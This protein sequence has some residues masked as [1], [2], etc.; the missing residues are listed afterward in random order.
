MAIVLTDSRGVE[1]TLPQTAKIEGF[2]F[3]TRIPAN[4]VPGRP[5]AIVSTSWVAK[6]SIKGTLRVLYPGDTNIAAETWRRVLAAIFAYP[7]I[8]LVRDTSIDDY[9]NVWC[10]NI[11]A[12]YI[13]RTNMSYIELTCSLVAH[14]P[15]FNATELTEVDGEITAV[16]GNIS[17]TNS[18]TGLVRPTITIV[19]SGTVGGADQ[20]TDITIVN[21]TTNQTI[22]YTGNLEATDT[23]VLDCENYTAKINGVS[24]FADVAGLTDVFSLAAGSNTVSVVAATAAGGAGDV[25]ISFR[26]RWH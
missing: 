5:G 1:Y 25:T 11:L 15:Y 8:M 13:E 23:L 21:T 7:P 12:R 3:P 16:A 24:V 6:G 4:V 2:D 10:E 17:V 9:I 19:G 18:G 20:M 22:T 14:D 26:A